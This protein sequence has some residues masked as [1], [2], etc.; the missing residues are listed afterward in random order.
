MSVLLAKSSDV[1]LQLAYDLRIEE[2]VFAKDE[3]I[4]LF[5]SPYSPK[6]AQTPKPQPV[7]LSNSS[8]M[9][10]TRKK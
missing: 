5:S 6:F 2:H 10:Y 7:P 3:I 1:L 8:V 4:K 9:G